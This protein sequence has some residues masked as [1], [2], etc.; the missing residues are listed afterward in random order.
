MDETIAMV[1]GSGTDVGEV[2][3]QCR[4]YIPMEGN[5]KSGAEMPMP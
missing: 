4:E 1:K 5:S 3:E 2:T